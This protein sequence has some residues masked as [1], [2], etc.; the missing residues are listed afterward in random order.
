MA[1]CQHI[2]AAARSCKV[3]TFPLKAVTL[4]PGQTS[5]RLNQLR[6]TAYAKHL[7]VHRV[8]DIT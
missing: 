8:P 6:A 5:L 3:I 7:L 4:S 1:I 2:W